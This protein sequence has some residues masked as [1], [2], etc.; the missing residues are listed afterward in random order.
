MYSA[1]KSHT[2]AFPKTAW[3]THTHSHTQ[4]WFA[5]W[6]LYV[7]LN[8]LYKYKPI[9]MA[10]WVVGGMEKE[11]GR[12]IRRERRISTW[13]W[14]PG[15]HNHMKSFLWMTRKVCEEVDDLNEKYQEPERTD[16][17]RIKACSAQLWYILLYTPALCSSLFCLLFGSCF[18][19][20]D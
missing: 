15:R 19:R 14:F 12:E 8:C 1:V 13:P 11:G 20:S 16:T 6:L 7:S 5:A 9:V 4:P 2:G 18:L 10:S 17:S 3:C